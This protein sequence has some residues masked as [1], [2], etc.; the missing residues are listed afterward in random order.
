[1]AGDNEP[2]FRE[3]NALNESLA[4]IKVVFRD[5]EVYAIIDVHPANHELIH[6]A[7]RRLGETITRFEGIDTLFATYA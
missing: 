1:L 7:V 2:T 6:D 4:N 3:I 5:D